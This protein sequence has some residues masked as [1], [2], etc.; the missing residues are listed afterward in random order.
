MHAQ[1]KAQT[2]S[3]KTSSLHL[4]LTLGTKTAYNFKI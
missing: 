1:G 4:R 2:R 3:E